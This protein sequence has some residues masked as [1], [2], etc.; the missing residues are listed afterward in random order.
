[1]NKVNKQTLDTDTIKQNLIEDYL[2]IKERISC[3]N[4]ETK[5]LE[6]KL[7][8]VSDRYFTIFNDDIEIASNTKPKTKVSK[9]VAN[10]VVLDFEEL[11]QGRKVVGKRKKYY[12]QY[13]EKGIKKIQYFQNNYAKTK[14]IDSLNKKANKKNTTINI[15]TSE[16]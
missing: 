12:L 15:V 14:K 10:T 2:F 6:M 5:K 7:K 3:N 1:M 9:N 8:E 4:T 13:E 11:E 16:L